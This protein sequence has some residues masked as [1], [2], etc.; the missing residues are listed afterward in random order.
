MLYLHYNF[1]ASYFSQ[2]TIIGQYLW[3]TWSN[4]VH[5]ITSIDLI[6]DCNMG[7]LV[8][9]SALFIAKQNVHQWIH[10][11]DN[12]VAWVHRIMVLSLERLVF[13]LQEKLGH[14]PIMKLIGH[15]VVFAVMESWIYT[16]WQCH[17][18]IA[19]T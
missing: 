4:T 14:L 10:M 3:K 6:G 2:W 11:V 8:S 15:V 7:G 13:A 17:V 5:I 18:D 1:G 16:L 9:R 19:G 12:M